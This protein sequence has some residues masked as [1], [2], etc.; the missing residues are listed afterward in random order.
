LA[1]DAFKPLPGSKVMICRKD[2]FHDTAWRIPCVRQ[3]FCWFYE[4]ETKKENKNAHRC[5]ILYARDG[6]L[7]TR[8]DFVDGD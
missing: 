3:G 2:I 1:L 6:D 7:E 8:V 5:A 4:P